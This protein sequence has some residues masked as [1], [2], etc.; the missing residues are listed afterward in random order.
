MYQGS[1]LFSQSTP[2]PFYQPGRTKG[3]VGS[4]AE[5]SLRSIMLKPQ[6]NFLPSAL[7][8][9]K[10]GSD[11]SSSNDTAVLDIL[12]RVIQQHVGVDSITIYRTGCEKAKSCLKGTCCRYD[13]CNERLYTMMLTDISAVPDLHE[14]LPP[15]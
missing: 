15:T 10:A 9:C 1:V 5:S 3:L 8:R 6:R 2:I 11:Y 4:R 12:K 13:G 14:H 7:H